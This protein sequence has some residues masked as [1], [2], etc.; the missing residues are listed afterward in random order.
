MV[1]DPKELYHDFWEIVEG[2]LNSILFVMIGLLVVHV[3]IS[4]YILILFPAAILINL[5]ARA[6][7]VSVSSLLTGA[8]HIPGN[9]S[10]PEYVVLMTWS[11]LKGGLSLALAL[12]TR[13][14][15]PADVYDIFINVTY[16]TIFFTV[17]VQGLTVK[18]AYYALEQHKT[19]RMSQSR[20]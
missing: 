10:I 12:G 14:Y 19:E 16:I 15:L 4:R 11:A 20:A 8:N 17:L 7:G 5:C 1:V 13:E 3:D 18:K 9:Y 6:F 2:L